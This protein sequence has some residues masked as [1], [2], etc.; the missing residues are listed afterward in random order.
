MDKQQVMDR[1]ETVALWKAKIAQDEAWA[2]RA[3][4]RIYAQQ[5]S[6]EISAGYTES[7]N[8]VG[9]SKHDSKFLSSVA[10]GCKKW[11][12][13]TAKQAKVVK[14]MMPKYA[15]QLFRLTYPDYV[16]PPRR[17]PKKEETVVTQ[18]VLEGIQRVSTNQKT[19]VGQY[20]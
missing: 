20:S 11:G 14:K 9:F 16:A 6:S 3:L 5:T 17:S 19:P 10:K 8:G 1:D 12:H 15:G 7:S 13:M 4:L 2:Q 18:D